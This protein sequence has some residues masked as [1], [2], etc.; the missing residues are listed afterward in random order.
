MTQNQI[1]KKFT[2]INF[3]EFLKTMDK[4]ETDTCRVY[5]EDC[6]FGLFVRRIF[7]EYRTVTNWDGIYYYSYRGPVQ[8]FE[9]PTWA[10]DYLAYL[11]NLVNPN[12]REFA[13]IAKTATIKFLTK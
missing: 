10:K 3:L 9:Y 4:K 5:S 12:S 6:F 7:P 1:N 2:K 13:K 11:R 8:V